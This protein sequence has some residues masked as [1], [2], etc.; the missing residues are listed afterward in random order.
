[1]VRLYSFECRRFLY[2]RRERFLLHEWLRDF[3]MLLEK[4]P[5]NGVP[6]YYNLL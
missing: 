4:W 2:S 5:D 6:V 3:P 1:M